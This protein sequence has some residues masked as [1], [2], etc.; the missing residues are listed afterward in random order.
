[1][2]AL[3]AECGSFAGISYAPSCKTFP[4]QHN[5]LVIV[6]TTSGRIESRVK[7]DTY[8][9]AF[10]ENS[11]HCFGNLRTVGKAKYPYGI[12]AL[13]RMNRELRVF[14]IRIAGPLEIGYLFLEPA[15][16]FQ[17]FA[18]LLSHDMDLSLI[19]I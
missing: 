3:V 14:A 16:R 1:M 7:Y 8:S 9:I 5:P 2:D 12:A 13:R 10:T 4:G 19:H 15:T 17:C 18:M 6:V 11:G